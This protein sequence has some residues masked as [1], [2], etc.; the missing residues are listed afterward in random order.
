MKKAFF[1]A[2]ALATVVIYGAS[3]LVEVAFIGERANQREKQ[4]SLFDTDAEHGISLPMVAWRSK[5][6]RE[7]SSTTT[8]TGQ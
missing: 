1:A 7:G 6:P 4:S 2:L 5:N 8:M 3:L